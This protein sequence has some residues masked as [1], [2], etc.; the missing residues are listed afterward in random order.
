MF[1]YHTHHLGPGAYESISNIQTLSPKLAK[2]RF[3][4]ITKKSPKKQKSAAPSIPCNNIYI[5]IYLVECVKTSGAHVGQYD[6]DYNSIKSRLNSLPFPKEGTAIEEAK[7][8]IL[9]GLDNRSGRGNIYSKHK[10]G[11]LLD[12]FKASTKTPSK[13]QAMKNLEKEL[14]LIENTRWGDD[15]N[16]CSYVFKSNTSKGVQTPETGVPGPGYYKNNNNEIENNLYNGLIS[17]YGT[18]GHSKKNSKFTLIDN[19]LVFVTH[20]DSTPSVGQYTATNNRG[21]PTE[22]LLPSIY[23]YIYIY[24]YRFCFPFK[25]S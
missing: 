7:S 24:I 13:E 6:P 10:M 5:Y 2:Q 1:L 9:S 14:E 4:A 19:A 11:L 12:Q 25:L 15:K 16:Q 23:I 22:P 21:N 3:N 18:F 17:K 8:G 20:K